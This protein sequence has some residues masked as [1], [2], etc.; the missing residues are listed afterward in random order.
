[1]FIKRLVRFFYFGVKET[2]VQKAQYVLK[3][4]YLHIVRAGGGQWTDLVARWVNGQGLCQMEK[5]K[6]LYVLSWR[7]LELF[8]AF[9]TLDKL[10]V[11]KYC[12]REVLCFVYKPI[13][14]MSLWG[15]TRSNFDWLSLVVMI[16]L[17][18]KQIYF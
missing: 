11:A 12:S 15:N 7:G 1:M 17:H 16:L 10:P 4:V 13:L 8:Y 3:L 5:A 18:T 6:V 14:L 9:E 2:D